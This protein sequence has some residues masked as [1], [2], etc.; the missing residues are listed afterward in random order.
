MQICIRVY[1]WP[2][3]R[4][5]K[6]LHPG[7]NLLLPSRWCKFICTRVQIVHMNANCIISIHYDGRFRFLLRCCLKSIKNKFQVVSYRKEYHVY[8]FNHSSTRYLNCYG[9][10]RSP[11]LISLH[12][13]L[14]PNTRAVARLVACPHCMQTV[15]I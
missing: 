1:F 12:I 3:E 6:N 10:R 14:N 7:A 9:Y 15:Q 5:F 11:P 2:C 8:Y 4:C 13:F